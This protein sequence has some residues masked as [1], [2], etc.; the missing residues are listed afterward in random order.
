MDLSGERRLPAARDTVWNALSDMATL[1]E[2][3]PPDTIA[4][5]G[6]DRVDITFAGS[7]GSLHVLARPDAA[8]GPAQ[9]V[10]H[11]AAPGDGHAPSGRFELTMAEDGIFTRLIWRLAADIRE[12]ER[13]RVEAAIDHVLSQVGQ[14]AATPQP[15]AAQGMA[16]AVTAVA[17]AAP[18]A[19]VVADNSPLMAV[20]RQLAAMPRD[21]T[22]GGAVFVLVVMFVVGIL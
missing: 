13:P 15:I 18:S 19:E 20:L 6:D 7:A 21:S 4:V 22:I 8:N 9:S 3:L 5:A 10:L 12:E 17:D 14:R 1:M 11:L 2:S 16:G